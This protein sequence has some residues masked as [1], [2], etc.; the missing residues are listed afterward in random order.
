VKPSKASCLVEIELFTSSRVPLFRSQRT[1]AFAYPAWVQKVTA[2]RALFIKLGAKGA[3]EEQCI[4]NR[5]MRVGYRQISHSLCKTGRW[6]DVKKRYV[7]KG[8]QQ[9]EATR[10][11]NELKSFYTAGRETIWITFYNRKLWWAFADGPVTLDKDK[12]KYRRMIDDWCSTDV[13]SV[14]LDFTKISSRL[15]KVIGYRGTICK[16]SELKY[17]LAK[18][19]GEVLP[20]V[21]EAKSAREEFLRTIVPLI[22]NLT[23]RD[24]E[25]LVDLVFT[26][27]GWRR[28]SV[29]GKTEKD[30]DLDM[31]QPVSQERIMVQVKSMAS[32]AVAREVIRSATA[33]TQY[34]RVFLVTHSF[35]GAF[36]DN[37]LDRVEIVD[38][39]RLAPLVL[40][41]GLIDWLL[42]KSS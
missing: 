15:T 35:D 17:L 40:D 28:L 33:L 24:F 37:V 21:K 23:W 8:E 11:A 34:R 27:G 38:T 20:E 30:I 22:R 41:A 13:D 5:I 6:D 9:K 14:D 42:E 2:S 18:L 12:Y 36:D 26:S 4:S 7:K 19:N 25:L 16:V 1:T 39:T 32:S 10:F 29:L 31:V 3:W